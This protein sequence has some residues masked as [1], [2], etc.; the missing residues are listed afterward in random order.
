MRVDREAVVRIALGTAADV[1]HAGSR[2]PITP[3]RASRAARPAFTG[4]DDPHERPR[5]RSVHATGAIGVTSRVEEPG[6]GP[7]ARLSDRGERLQRLVRSGERL[8]RPGRHRCA[9]RH[10]PGRSRRSSGPPG[11][12]RR[13]RISPSSAIR[14]GSSPNPIDRATGGCSSRAGDR[15]ARAGLELRALRARVR[16]SWRRRSS[17]SA[18]RSKASPTTQSSSGTAWTSRSPS[19]SVLEVRLE[20]MGR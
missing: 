3:T 17:R 5:V 15:R 18:V 13:P 10:G 6:V 19:G 11:R 2:V 14:R 12:A 7:V 4:S 16:N 9:R 20:Q 1:S 8:R